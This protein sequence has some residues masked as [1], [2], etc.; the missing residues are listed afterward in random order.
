MFRSL[1]A[2]RVAAGVAAIGLTL[3]LL[4]GSPPLAPA[5]AAEPATALPVAPTLYRSAGA[6]RAVRSAARSASS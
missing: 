1:P 4:A 5:S 6:P 3:G 2:R